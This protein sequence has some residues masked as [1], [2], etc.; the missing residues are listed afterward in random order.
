MTVEM[1][2]IQGP[3]SVSTILAANKYIDAWHPSFA[4]RFVFLSESANWGGIYWISQVEQD[5]SLL[6][7]LDQFG[8]SGSCNRR[9]C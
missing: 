7:Q 3:V 6:L 1:E 9:G 5:W 4:N 8:P 2:S